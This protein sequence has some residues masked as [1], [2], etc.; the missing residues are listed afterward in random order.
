MNTLSQILTGLIFSGFICGCNQNNNEIKKEIAND[1]LSEKSISV[2]YLGD[3]LSRRSFAAVQFIDNE[4]E[5]DAYLEKQEKSNPSLLP[6]FSK[7]DSLLTYYFEKAG[8]IKGDELLLYKFKKQIEEEAYFVDS[9]GNKASLKFYTDSTTSQI[10]FKIFF[11]GD[12]LAI[13]TESRLPQNLDYAFI[14]IV[15]G[16]NKELV[17]L[18]DYY[19]MNGN[20]FYF[21]VYE[22]NLR[23]KK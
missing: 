17:F 9:A 8:L 10:H 5:Q 6:I 16:D 23:R 1:S 20:N 3:V 15:P 19:I 7:K 21:L 22:I 11:S 13:N 18:D 4:K 14:D 12:S 2:V